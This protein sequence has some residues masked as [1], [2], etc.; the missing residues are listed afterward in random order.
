M[1]STN[2]FSRH[3]HPRR[4]ATA[5]QCRPRVQTRHA[6]AFFAMSA[7]AAAVLW[8]AVV[9]EGRAQSEELDPYNLRQMIGQVAPAWSTQGWVNSKALDLKSLRGKVVLLRFINDHP[10]GASS[11]K[12]LYG[13]YRDQ[14]LVVVALY[15]PEPMPQ[16]TSLDYVETL[17]TSMGFTFPVGLDSRW[18]TVNRYWLLRADAGIS[19][20]T[21]VIDRKGI[22]RY[23]QPDGLYEKNS[24][25]SA[26]RKE[27][28]KLENAI[29]TLLKPEA[30]APGEKSDQP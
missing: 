22:I 14:G 10:A 27:Y 1:A 8:S 19:G 26:A 9:P 3:H 20:T 16:E 24:R 4:P 28:E 17:A 6:R 21:F 29:Q 11:L 12:E 13:A 5:L 23:I 25:R 30:E 15:T 7:L 18:E 2:F